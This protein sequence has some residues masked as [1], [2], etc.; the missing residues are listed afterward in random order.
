[1]LL[2]RD[3]QTLET[4]P[5]H[6]VGFGYVNLTTHGMVPATG[7]CD[8]RRHAAADRR[9]RRR[10]RLRVP[11]PLGPGAC[12]ARRPPP[13]APG[14]PR[15]HVGVGPHRA[16]RDRP[17]RGGA[18]TRARGAVTCVV[19][20]S[21]H[22]TPAAR[23]PRRRRPR[24]RLGERAAVRRWRR[25]SRPHRAGGRGVEPVVRV[26]PRRHGGRDPRRFPAR[27]RRSPHA[28]FHRNVVVNATYE[29]SPQG[30]IVRCVAPPLPWEAVTVDGL[31][32][33]RRTLAVAL[34]VSLNGQQFVA[35]QAQ[36]FA[37]RACT[38]SRSRRR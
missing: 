17:L 29:D 18:A 37:H 23:P 32:P 16:L 35:P 24:R 6:A 38:S 25:R 33:V 14:R 26:R 4:L 5:R 7:R 36:G 11:L 15:R 30:G 27:R 3:G 13:R 9:R 31:P 21:A 2:V 8:R 10:R 20:R 12:C 34:S 19:P 22:R 1:M 28:R